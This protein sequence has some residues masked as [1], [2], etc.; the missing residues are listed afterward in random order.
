M[1]GT[2]HDILELAEHKPFEALD[3]SERN[4]VLAQMPEQAYR[5]M[6]ESARLMRQPGPAPIP[7]PALRE[8]ILNQVPVSTPWH[9]RTVSLPTLALGC[10]LTGLGVYCLKTTPAAAPPAAQERIIVHKTDTVYLEKIKWKTQVI[11]KQIFIPTSI[12]VAQQPD[13]S[14][15]PVT[16]PVNDP[17]PDIQVS[18]QA[19]AI[20]TQPGLMQFFTPA[21]KRSKK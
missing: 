5:A 13:I 8:A 3:A 11:E 7:S 17:Y 16:V 6:Y 4:F 12:P 9:Q 10:L 15:A 19:G 2:M 14:P 18:D 1:N 21:N 20:G